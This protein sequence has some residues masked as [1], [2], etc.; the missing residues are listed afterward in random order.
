[1]NKFG[2]KQ[3]ITPDEMARIT[4]SILL[5]TGVP[6]DWQGSVNKVDID[7]LIEF[8]FN[9][10]IDWKDIDYLAPGEL[11]LAAIFPKHKRICMN[12]TQ[13]A[14]FLEKM[15]T[16]NF[17]KA[18]EL[19][20]WV[21]HVTE[22]VEYAQLSFT[23][24]DTYFCRSTSKKPPQEFQADMFA[25]SILMPKNIIAGVVNELKKQGSVAWPELY[26]LKDDFEVS[27][28]ALTTRIQELKLLSIV[29]KKIYMSEAD[30][31]RQL[32]LF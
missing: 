27:I 17:S 22:Q 5:K 15:G 3:F 8:D 28:S 6:I 13:K 16:M 23:E 2:S 24:S 21:L 26:K 1:M 18:H 10:E 25:A 14:L 20:H 7:A 31:I 9:L 4:E 11:V 32:T 19:G 30:A 12:E 29:D